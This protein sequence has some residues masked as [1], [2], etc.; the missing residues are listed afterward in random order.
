MRV[1]SIFALFCALALMACSAPSD[2]RQRTQD[3]WARV[4]GR[5]DAG[6]LGSQAALQTPD[7]VSAGVPFTITVSTYGSTG[8]IHPDRSDIQQ[9]Q[10]S[11]DVTAYDSLWVGSPACLPDW[12]PYPRALELRFGLAGPAFIRLHGRGAD[13]ALTFERAIIVRP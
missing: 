5:V 11:V 8:C 1:R 6:P 2:G 7:S 3:A 10:S 9:G 4:V 13:S 12:H